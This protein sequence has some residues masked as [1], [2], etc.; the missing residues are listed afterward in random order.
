MC[1]V[2]QRKA[3]GGFFQTDFRFGVRGSLQNVW[4][5]NGCTRL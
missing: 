1:S 4:I 3:A 2:A 5:L